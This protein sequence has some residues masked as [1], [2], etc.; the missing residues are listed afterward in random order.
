MPPIASLMVPKKTPDIKRMCCL[1]AF[2]FLGGA[3][4]KNQTD[5]S[6]ALATEYCEKVKPE[7]ESCLTA[8]SAAFALS[9]DDNKNWRNSFVQCLKDNSLEGEKRLYKLPGV[10]ALQ[11]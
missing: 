7:L 1:L 8:M 6:I 4:Q 2:S 9:N 5:E 3:P 10:G 11:N